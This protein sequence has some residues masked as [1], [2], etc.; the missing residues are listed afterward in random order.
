M[1]LL[2]LL[3]HPFTL[4]L[5][6]HLLSL[7]FYTPGS[8]LPLQKHNVMEE[9]CDIALTDPM[10]S[11]I[12][13][14]ALHAIDSLLDYPQGLERFLGWNKRSSSSGPGPMTST[15]YQHML[16]LVL[17]QPVSV[18]CSWSYTSL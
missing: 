1:Y 4:S 12:K 7:S 16:N 8:S 6:L 5:M 15:A 11:T 17:S 3:M 14:Q 18:Y 10:A 13:L 9:L 2:P